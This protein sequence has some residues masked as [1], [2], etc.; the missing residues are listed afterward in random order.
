MLVL[1]GGR[2]KISE[3]MGDVARGIKSFRKGLADDEK[4][5][6]QGQKDCRGDQGPREELG[7]GRFHVRH[8]LERA[9]GH[10]RRRAIGDR[11]ER[12][13]AGASHAGAMDR[14]GAGA[15]ARFPGPCRRSDARVPSRRHEARVSRDD[16][17][18]RT[19]RSGRRSD[20]GRR[21]GG[22]ERAAR[23]RRRRR[24]NRSPSRRRH[25]EASSTTMRMSKPRAR[26]CSII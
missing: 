10:R 19:R 18:A 22:K 11:T 14:Q 12:L 17:S 3:M 25:D 8:R 21:A 24:T 9:S 5:L 13:A 4:P 6:E 26:R 20:G 23:R 16:A 2:G 7:R 15:G 1:F